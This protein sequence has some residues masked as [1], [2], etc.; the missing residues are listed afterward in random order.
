[1]DAGLPAV[2]APRRWVFLRSSAAAA[3]SALMACGG[4]NGSSPTSPSAPGVLLPGPQCRNYATHY[5]RSVTGVGNGTTSVANADCSLAGPTYT[6]TEV[7]QLYCGTFTNSI[8]RTYRGISDFVDEAA[9]VG[10]TRVLRTEQSVRYSP[11]CGPSW[12]SWTG[13]WT[14]SYDSQGRLTGWVARGEVSGGTVV[15]TS[16]DSLG[17]PAG[18]TFTWSPPGA[19]CG[20]VQLAIVYDDAGRTTTETWRGGCVRTQTSE[21]DADGNLL[22]LTTNDPSGTSTLVNTITATTRVCQ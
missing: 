11:S 22:K 2:R 1:M 4:G 21:Y 17:R 13:T 12:L 20:S 5:T 8:A 16:W 6:C 15:Y 14:L 10:R 7:E 19:G 18:G 3:V 9:V